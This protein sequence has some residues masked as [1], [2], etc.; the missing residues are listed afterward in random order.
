MDTWQPASCEEVEIILA[1]ELEELNPAHR[2]RFESMRVTPRKVP[3]TSAPGEYVHVVA[4]YG[5]KVLYWSDVEEGWEL[6]ALDASGGI[7]KRACNQFDL[8]HIM[9]QVFGGAV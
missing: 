9:H 3:V 5:G 4:E 6:E 2:T 7:T 1:A 8:T